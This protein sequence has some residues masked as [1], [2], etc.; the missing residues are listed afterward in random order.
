MSRGASHS[1]D[2]AERNLCTSTRCAL[3]GFARI[4]GRNAPGKKQFRRSGKRGMKKRSRRKATGRRETRKEERG[5]RTKVHVVARVTRG[6]PRVVGLCDTNDRGTMT[7]AGGSGV[8]VGI[9]LI[10]WGAN[11]T[12]ANI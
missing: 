3:R 6:S 5:K 8:G 12:P 11:A 9:S 1:G 10:K 4:D 7:R 2:A